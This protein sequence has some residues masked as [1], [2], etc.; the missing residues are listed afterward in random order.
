VVMI[1]TVPHYYGGLTNSLEYKGITLDFTFQYSKRTRSNDI[2]TLN[3]SV[4][5]RA[6]NIPLYVFENSWRKP[7]DI[8]LFQKF[9][10]STNTSAY[11]SRTTSVSEA[12]Y[13]DVMLLRL[14]NVALSWKLPASLQ[15][16]H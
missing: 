1:N 15:D 13:M 3:G 6:N 16:K 4:P 12:Y 10:Q 8:A 11:R 14:N 9:T 2:A 7:G 5:G